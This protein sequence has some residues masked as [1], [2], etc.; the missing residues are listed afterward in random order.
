MRSPRRSLSVFLSIS[1]YFFFI[2]L[3]YSTVAYHLFAQTTSSEKKDVKKYLYLK[4]REESSILLVWKM[5]SRKGSIDAL[6]EVL[7][8][9]ET[10]PLVDDGLLNTTRNRL[11]EQP[12][13]ESPY[14]IV[15]SL[16]RWCEVECNSRF[17][18][19][20]LAGK[21]RSLAGVEI[22]EAQ[23]KRFLTDVPN[24]PSLSLQ[25][26]LNRIRAFEAWDVVRQN[27]SDT[28]RIIIGIVDSGVDYLHEDLAAVIYTNPRESGMDANGRDRR[29]NG[30]DDDQNGKVDDWRGWDFVGADGYT[31]DNDPRATFN[32]HGTHVAGIVGA[33]VNNRVGVAGTVGL[34]SRVRLLP[35]KCARDMVDSRFVINGAKGVLYA[36][37]QGAQIVNC[38]WGSSVER[39]FAEQELLSAARKLGTFIVFSAGNDGDDVPNYPAAYPNTF[40]VAWLNEN[41][42]R[43]GGGS[44]YPSVDLAAQGSSVYATFPENQ[45]G[46]KSGSSMA[47]P[48][49]TAA[50]ALV[51]MRFP[52]MTPDQIAQQL[53]ASAD[54]IDTL[55]QSVAG[56]LGAGRLNMLRAVQSQDIQS[57]S[58]QDYT[59]AD[60]NNNG[61]LETGER[62]SITLHLRAGQRAVEGAFAEMR[63][64]IDSTSRFLPFWD[65]L[66]KPLPALSANELRRSAVSFTFKL[67][68]TLPQDFRI[69]L[70]FTFRS[71]TSAIIGRDGMDLVANLSY[72]TMSANNVIATI[73]SNGGLGY[74]ASQTEGDGV[75]FKLLPTESLLYSG[76]LMIASAADSVSNALR[77]LYIF[78]RDRSFV[79][80]SL[81]RFTAPPDSSVLLAKAAFA[82]RGGANDA[83]VSVEQQT[84]Q[85]RSVRQQNMLIQS[86]KITNTSQRNFTGLYAGMFL[87]WDIGRALNNETY[88]NDTLKVAIARNTDITAKLPIVAVQLL[89]PQKVNFMPMVIGDTVQ[90]AISLDGF[91]RS[92]KYKSLSSGIITRRK[93][94]DVSHVLGAGPITLSSNASTTVN[95]AIIL[96]S[97][98]EELRSILL[99]TTTNRPPLRAYPNPSPETVFLDYDL[100][101]EQA[102]SVDVVNTLGQVI[103]QPI[104]NQLRQKGRNQEEINL[105]HLAGGVY[106][107]RLRTQ[108][109]LSTASVLISR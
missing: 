80:T 101:S 50:A 26:H 13:E 4:F 31:E 67:T 27:T 97:S 20:F 22:A 1:Q 66:R 42:T 90:G 12:S 106:F 37:S 2:V 33:V 28:N 83:G 57:V 36:A 107:V 15:E 46:F 70:T 104:V 82:D 16:S 93:I 35:V 86:W 65:E 75:T 9:H 91:P 30:I 98:M 61:I 69:P 88:W 48:Q 38:S 99:D 74:G 84:F 19:E 81:I 58:V 109:G 3:L 102:V 85:Y 23:P 72:R 100:P 105:S 55:N 77:G 39:S 56:L 63:S 32:D 34:S 43:A 87:D 60:E 54:N 92:D 89:T 7:G 41:D 44:Y 94:G 8:K 64:S 18:A 21:L 96:A 53:K 108:V 95:I 52:S 47:A 11:L 79:P 59:I 25:T 51:K 73:T 10:K 71:T 14:P 76:G 29:T 24:D 6:S 40:S 62:I 49:V 68:Q 78:G 45:Y 103:A 17:D 5:N